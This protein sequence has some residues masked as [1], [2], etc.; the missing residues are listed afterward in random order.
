MGSLCRA[1]EQG[2]GGAW[3]RQRKRERERGER[4]ERWGRGERR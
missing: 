2:Q 4:G 1:A 3:R